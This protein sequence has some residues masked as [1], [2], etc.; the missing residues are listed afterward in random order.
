MELAKEFE[1]PQEPPKLKAVAKRKIPKSP[2]IEF[3]LVPEMHER[4]ER[5]SRLDGKPK[6]D[7]VR[8]AIEH[9]VNSRENNL[10]QDR[11]A[12][13]EKLIKKGVN[14]IAA[15][16]VRNAIDTGVIYNLLWQNLPI[17][18]RGKILKKAYRESTERLR[19]KLSAQEMEMKEIFGQ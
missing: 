3:R 17:A 11:D 8:D 14:R 1:E 2:L 15:L 12:A 18:E 6:T 19:T 9:Y 13:L 16:V 7:V 4:L 10:L 5:I